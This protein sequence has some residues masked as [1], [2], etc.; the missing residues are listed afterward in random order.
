[1]NSQLRKTIFYSYP[2]ISA[3]QAAVRFAAFTYDSG[4]VPGWSGLSVRARLCYGVIDKIRYIRRFLPTRENNISVLRSL[5]PIIESTRN[6]VTSI[7]KPKRHPAQTKQS[8][9]P[10]SA[11]N[12][13]TK[14]VLCLPHLGQPS[15][16][17]SMHT[18]KVS[19]FG[20]SH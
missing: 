13:G 6:S 5:V 9:S 20:P 3:C 2:V 4:L 15:S 16:K 17:K 8:R 10:S 19:R 18:A 14:L 7:G 12:C 1:M 11:I